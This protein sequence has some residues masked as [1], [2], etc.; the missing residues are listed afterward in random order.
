LCKLKEFVELLGGKLSLHSQGGSY[1]YKNGNETIKDCGYWPGSIVALKLNLETV[2]TK[3]ELII[4]INKKNSNC[5][6]ILLNIV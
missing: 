6:D 3:K 4:K 1:T 2:D 5:D